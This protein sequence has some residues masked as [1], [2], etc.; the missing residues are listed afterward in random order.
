MDT[1]RSAV[2]VVGVIAG[3]IG[4]AFLAQ[5]F[6]EAFGSPSIAGSIVTAMILGAIVY[7]WITARS[8]G[9]IT[10]RL[11]AGA[12]RGAVIDVISWVIIPYAKRIPYIWDRTYFTILFIGT[13][14]GGITGWR[15]AIQQYERHR[16]PNIPNYTNNG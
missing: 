12:V 7:A 1:K 14:G 2:G 8:G 10:G 9:A 16:N 5:L 3:S 6:W 11:M 4:G 15:K 13:I